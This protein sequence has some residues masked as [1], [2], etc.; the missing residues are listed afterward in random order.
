MKYEV[1]RRIFV[2]GTRF[3]EL[4]KLKEEPLEEMGVRRGEL[5]GLMSL[6]FCLAT[7]R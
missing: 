6:T 2:N 5:S 4:E 3:D 1:N 7:Y